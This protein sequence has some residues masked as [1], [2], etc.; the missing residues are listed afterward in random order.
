ML[1]VQ[2]SRYTAKG[3]LAPL[4]QRD[5]PEVMHQY[6]R[7]AITQTPYDV[8]P[9]VETEPQTDSKTELT[10]AEQ[11]TKKQSANARKVELVRMPGAYR[12]FLQKVF[13]DGKMKTDDDRRILD[14]LHP[15]PMAISSRFA[16]KSKSKAET[17]TAKASKPRAETG[18][19]STEKGSTVTSSHQ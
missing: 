12:Q 17:S 11:S 6:S 8:E 9:Q 13:V 2:Q 7:K 15:N 4:K 16:Q 3:C 1:N 18:T 5:E 19:T 10:K 14:F